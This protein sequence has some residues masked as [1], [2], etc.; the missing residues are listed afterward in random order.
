LAKGEQLDLV[1]DI[2]KRELAVIEAADVAFCY[3]EAERQIIESHILQ[4]G[5]VKI[6]PWVAEAKVDK[7]VAK[8]GGKFC[9]LGS[10]HHKPNQE[11][12]EF[13]KTVLAK[14]CPD[15]EFIVGGYGW[16]KEKVG[17]FENIGKI[18]DLVEFFSQ[19]Q[20]LIVPLAS[21]AGIKG[22]IF[23][24]LSC[25]LPVI[26]TQVG[27]EGIPIEGNEFGEVVALSD[28]GK[29]VVRFNAASRKNVND[30]EKYAANSLDYIKSSLSLKS[31]CSKLMQQLRLTQ[32]KD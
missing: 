23:E 7:P 4:K 15:L 10:Q 11:A 12:V 25:G 1:Q 9:F 28:F 16:D 14:E 31:G 26:S 22:K 30:C 29:S 21:G 32:I 20:A 6:M 8:P 18:Q 3:T 2:R 19:C 5:K 17:N 13:I 24:A 27:A